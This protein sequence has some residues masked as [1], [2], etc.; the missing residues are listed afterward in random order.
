MQSL[1]PSATQRLICTMMCQSGLN[2]GTIVAMLGTDGWRINAPVKHG[3][4]LHVA[5]IPREKRL[6]SKKTTGV[7]TFDREI[8]NQRG[9][10]ILKPQ[11]AKIVRQFLPYD[12]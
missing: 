12:A 1:L 4:T 3:D 2:D 11:D 10:T 9:T 8:R 5:M 6:T 7:V